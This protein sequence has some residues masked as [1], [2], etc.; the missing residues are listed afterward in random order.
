[1][2][3]DITGAVA[4]GISAYCLAA[5]TRGLTGRP[6]FDLVDALIMIAAFS[7]GA[8]WSYRRFRSAP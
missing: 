7:I 4:V 5:I 8:F 3:Q 2:V 6:L 1:M